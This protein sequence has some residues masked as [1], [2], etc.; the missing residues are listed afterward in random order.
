MNEEYLLN[1]AQES[2]NKQAWIGTR[3]PFN[4]EVY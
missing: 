1:L 2:N 4:M 3:P